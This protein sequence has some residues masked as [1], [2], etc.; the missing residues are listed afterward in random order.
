M[1]R[2]INFAIS[3]KLEELLIDKG[4]KVFL[5]HNG[6]G[7]PLTSRKSRVNSFNAEISISIHNNAVPQNVD[8]TLHNG[9]SVYYYYRQA[10]PLAKFI[11]S[12]F[13]KNLGLKD[14]GLYWDNLY[15]CRIPESI[16]LLVE[17]AFMIIPSQEKKLLDVEYQR[18]IAEQLLKSIEQFYEEYAE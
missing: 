9:T 14:F 4:A 6:E 12:N 10:L 18:L 17:P 2:D 11:H 5:T 13:V 7:I 1:E 16:S 15:M 8:P 3:Q